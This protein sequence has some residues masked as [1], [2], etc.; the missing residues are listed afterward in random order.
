[1]TA[2]IEG[3]EQVSRMQVAAS[4]SENL[5]LHSS[6][7]ALVTGAEGFIGRVLCAKLTAAGYSVRRA[8]RGNP[9]HTPDGLFRVGDLTEFTG[10][11]DIVAGV[12]TV[13]H[14]ANRAHVVQ[15]ASGNAIET[16]REINVRASVALAAAAARAAVKRFVFVSSSHVNGVLSGTRAFMEEDVPAPVGPY[17]LSK[18]EAEQALRGIEREWGLAL[19]IVRPAPVYGPGVKGNILRLLKVVKARWPLPLGSVRNVRSFIGV[20][21]L[22]DLLILCASDPAARGALFLAAD[23]ED[24][25]TP[26]LVR[27]IAQ[28][29][30]LHARLPRVP[31]AAL[32]WLAT[33]SGSRSAFERLTGTLQVNSSRARDVLGWRPRRSLDEGISDMAAWFAQSGGAEL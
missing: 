29:M 7:C 21:N 1:V 22:A 5:R 24:V 12:D 28:A 18:W 2:A 33:L 14:L 4:V 32:R 16:F 26:D 6:R 20:E 19:T 9:N 27:L 25:S 13:F 11:S 23:G 10:W 31:L 8:V 30:G 15:E 17:A 3:Q